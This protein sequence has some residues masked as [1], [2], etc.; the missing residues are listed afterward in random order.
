MEA[1]RVAAGN[2]RLNGVGG[3]VRIVTAK[4]LDSGRLSSGGPYD[5]LIANILAGPL[6]ELAPK[7]RRIVARGGRTVLSGLLATQAAEVAA[8]FRAAGFHLERHD[9]LTGWATLTLVAHGRDYSGRDQRAGRRPR[10][11]G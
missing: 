10:R 7:L 3:R 5:L 1:T 2:A 11:A 4:G 6:I 8:A 9:V